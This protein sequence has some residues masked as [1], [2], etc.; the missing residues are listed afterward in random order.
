M[1]KALWYEGIQFD[2]YIDAEDDD[3]LGICWSYLCAEH[4]N[5]YCKMFPKKRITDCPAIATCSVKGC[6]HQARYCLDVYKKTVDMV[7]M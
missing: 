4:Y 7:K 1:S 5:E 2:N 3:E 6:D